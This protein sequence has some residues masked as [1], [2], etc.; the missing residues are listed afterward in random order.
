MHRAAYSLFE[1]RD[2]VEMGIGNATV[3]LQVKHGVGTCC[4]GLRVCV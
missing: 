1:V 4:I 2:G 3:Q